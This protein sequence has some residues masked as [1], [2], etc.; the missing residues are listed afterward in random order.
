LCWALELGSLLLRNKSIHELA[1]ALVGI[2]I[3]PPILAVFT[4]QEGQ[5][6][7][8]SSAT[9]AAAPITIAAAVL[10][11]LL[12]VIVTRQNG[13]K[14]SV[15]AR[16]CRREF[17]GLAITLRDELAKENPMPGLEKIQKDIAAIVQRNVAE[18][19]WPWEGPASRIARRVQKRL[20]RLC[21]EF[22][23]GWL[24]APEVDQF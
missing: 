20:D 14:R 9:A 18:D 19:S 12:K 1:A 22:E 8:V 21:T 11:M 17:R 4:G 10:W 23:Q 13:E 2:G 5:H 6:A 16:S 3:S 7:T 15:L 24:S